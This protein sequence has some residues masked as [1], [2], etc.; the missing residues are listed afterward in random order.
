MKKQLIS[1]LTGTTTFVLV[2]LLAGS[3][4]LVQSAAG[5]ENEL[6]AG[7]ARI[8]RWAARGFDFSGHRRWRNCSVCAITCPLRLR[9]FPARQKLAA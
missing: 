8:Q 4:H 3:N 7:Y 1:A 5:S 9:Y 2:A 6:A